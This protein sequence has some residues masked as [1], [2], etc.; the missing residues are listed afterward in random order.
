MVMHVCN[1][2]QLRDRQEDP[3]SEPT[4][5]VQSDQELVSE[6]KRRDMKEE[7]GMS[8]RHCLVVECLQSTHEA[9][10]SNPLLTR[11]EDKERIRENAKARF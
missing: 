6:E 5:L 11:K 8:W 4:C 7:R 1:H 3:N 9:Q 10:S 2:S